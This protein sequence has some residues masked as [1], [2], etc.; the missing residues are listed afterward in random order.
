MNERDDATPPSGK[1]A[2]L[3][4]PAGERQTITALSFDVAGSTELLED[5]GIEDYRDVMSAFQAL[6]QK[7]IADHGGVVEVD[8]GDGGLALF[9]ASIGAR[10]A[11]SLAI[12]AGRA[13]IR[14]GRDAG[15]APEGR[16]LTVRAGVATSISLVQQA[17]AGTKN[18]TTVTGRALAL[19]TRLQGLA[20]AGTVLVCGET[21]RLSGRSF[22]FKER[23]PVELKG[24]RTRQTVWEALRPQRAAHRFFSYGRVSNELEGRSGDLAWLTARWAE[25]S[26]GRGGTLLI[27]G[28]P[29]YGKSRLV[30]KLRAL[31]RGTRR[32][33]LLFQCIPGATG[34]PLHPILHRLQSDS[35]AADLRPAE[36]RSFAQRKFHEAGIADQAIYL[37]TYLLGLSASNQRLAAEG[38]EALHER[39]VNAVRQSI[40]DLCARGPAIIVVEDIHWLDPTS[41][42]LV[43]EAARIADEYPLLL[44][45][46]SRPTGAHEWL[47]ATDQN[48]LRLQPLSAADTL[49]A[50]QTRL[51]EVAESRPDIV[52]VIVR[53]SAGNPLFIEELCQWAAENG[54]ALIESL[55]QQDTPDVSST[56]ERIVEARL[57]ATADA[58][59]IASA[60]AVAGTRFDSALLSRLLPDMPQADIGEI[61]EKL[62][63][64]GF[65]VQHG[66]GARLLYGFRH[67]LIQEAVYAMMLSRRRRDLHKQLFHA[68]KA[69]KAL[70][71]W[72]ETPLLA[73]HAEN[74]GLLEEA[75]ATYVQAGK[76]SAERSAL[77]EARSLL[78]HASDLAQ[79]IT[80]P[81]RRDF[82]RLPVL[83]GLGPVLI[84][85]EGPGSTAARQ[86]YEDGVAIARQRPA[87]ER[88]QWFPLYWGWWF[89]G[90]EI[91]GS[92]AHQ[93]D[94]EM[95]GIEDTE[96]QLQTH[97]SVW[98][99]DFYLGRHEDCVNH[100]N[101]GLPLY[102]G[103]T[104]LRQTIQY[105]GHDCQ[106]C[107]L[108][109]RGLSLWFS[110][111]IAEATRDIHAA[112]QRAMALDH[113]G[114]LAHAIFHSATFN[115]YRREL[116]G[117]Q[118]DITS[119]RA[120]PEFGR[121]P[122]FAASADILQGWNK[123]LTSDL[124]GGRSMMEHGL[125]ALEMLQTP[126]DR[127]VYCGLQAEVLVALD[128][129][130]AALAILG[131]GIEAAQRTGH[132][133]WIAQLHRYR[134]RLLMRVGADG[135]LVRAA[136][137]EGLNIA[138][139]QGALALMIPLRACAME[140]GLTQVFETRYG[141]RFR[142]LAAKADSAAEFFVTPEPGWMTGAA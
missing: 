40:K 13:I 89:T 106:V 67:M 99:I 129:E 104:A 16:P 107:G 45:L 82:L 100:V 47:A 46:T 63:G 38:P 68:L 18:K 33:F 49:R 39:T 27:E 24:F 138:S 126:E 81:Q 21:R 101:A 123:A 76:E 118:A 71:P 57:A 52:E 140:I 91:N 30:H 131:Q 88:A 66:G 5:I 62:C 125:A 29:G 111:R 22:T 50:V 69:E 108:A 120:L 85:L 35:G 42:M 54:A 31:S 15:A 34:W 83:L 75:I 19:A 32:R 84:S 134:A 20:E 94:Q 51:S 113:G 37:F 135:D 130:V 127:A 10:D 114:S 53:I 60:A 79:T 1:V 141:E 74:G 12:S 64:S 95:H 41:R 121:L 115:C 86:V 124:V 132:L 9:P 14:A 48:R 58:A 23:G 103:A 65:L 137:R 98:A 105:G 102:D 8:L 11:A 25:A 26:S 136:V 55:S 122:N 119:M 59:P 6:A 112:R 36:L 93:L 61:L 97:H 78:N 116:Q 117:L 4:A 73:E 110:G 72:I 43:A 109:H 2:G 56:F 7:A 70:A 28:E 128:C 80:D 92:R 90:E 44:V 142:D 96:V 87:S 3:S 17:W 133:H 139:E 77:T